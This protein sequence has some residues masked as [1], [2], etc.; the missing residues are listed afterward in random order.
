MSMAYGTCGVMTNV[1]HALTHLMYYTG[2]P[3]LSVYPSIWKNECQY[4][5]MF[6][7][8]DKNQNENT[9]YFENV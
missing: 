5:C 2:N 8:N 4:I 6:K 9:K 1:I 7:F 3:L